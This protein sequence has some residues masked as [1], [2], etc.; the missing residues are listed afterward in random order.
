MKLCEDKAQQ[1]GGNNTKHADGSSNQGR[2]LVY[3][4]SQLICSHVQFAGVSKLGRQGRPL[5]LTLKQHAKVS[6]PHSTNNKSA[7]DNFVKI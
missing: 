2:Q 3:Q 4:L 5:C 6:N 1:K 7:A